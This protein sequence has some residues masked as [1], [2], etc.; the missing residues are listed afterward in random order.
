MKKKLK[1]ENIQ[2]SFGGIMAV[3]DVTLEANSGEITAIIGPNGAGKTTLINIISGIY[4]P[5]RGK[6]FVDSKDITGIPPYKIVKYGIKRTFQNIQTFSNMTLL[7][8]VMVGFHYATKYGFINCMLQ[9][10]YLRK[11]ERMIV[12]KSRK[13]LEEMNLTKYADYYPTELPYGIQKKLEIART[14]AGEPDI[15]LFDEPVA[16]LNIAE[17]YEISEIILNLKDKNK[18]ILLIEHDMNVVMGISDKIICLH[19]GKKIAEGIP[20]DI[21]KN[22]DVINAYLGADTLVI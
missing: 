13:I 14:L 3:S 18:T 2:K 17:S 22:K 20:S 4:K 12:E 1:V 15:I 6:I 8:N 16:G 9:M 10:N 5:D 11:Q 19:Y 7:E 21:Q